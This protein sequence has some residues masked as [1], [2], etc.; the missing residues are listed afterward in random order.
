MLTN[1]LGD[2]SQ[3]H[4]TYNVLGQALWPGNKQYFIAISYASHY[5]V[6][7]RYTHVCHWEWNA[8]I[9]E[10]VNMLFVVHAGTKV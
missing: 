9:D 8:C 6:H 1:Q 5:V 3:G 7:L 4:T 2:A 10:P